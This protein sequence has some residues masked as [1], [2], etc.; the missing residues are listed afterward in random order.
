MTEQTECRWSWCKPDKPG[1]WWWGGAQKTPTPMKILDGR[2]EDIT[3]VGWWAFVLS[4]PPEPLPPKRKVTQTLWMV[5]TLWTHH[6][7]GTTFVKAWLSPEDTI[8]P[9]AIETVQKREVEQ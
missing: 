2:C 7:G 8:P 5:P 9:G 1:L 6:S 4:I 3:M